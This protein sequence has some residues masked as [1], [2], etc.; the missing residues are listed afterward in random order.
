VDA[1]YDGRVTYT[2]SSMLD[3]IPD[4]YKKKPISLYDP[5][6]AS[7]L[8]QYRL[9][10]PRTRNF[11]E[12]VQFAT[13][14]G[15]YLFFMTERDAS[16]ISISEL[17]FAVYAFGW[18]LDQIATMLEHGWQVYTQNLWSFLDVTFSLLYTAYLLLRVHAWRTESQQL[19]Q[20]ALDVLAMGAPVLVPRIAFVVLSDNLLFVCL[21]AM[22]ADFALLTALAAWCFLGFLLSL[23]W[24][25]EGAHPTVTISKWMIYIWFG[26]DGTGIQRSAEFHWLLGPG[27]MV[28]FAFLGNTLFLTILV[29][30]LSNTFGTIV[31]N[32]TA[33]IQYRHAVLTLEGVKSDAIFAYQP[34]FNILALVV[35]VP[36]KFLVSPR[37]FHKIHVASVRTLNLPLLL[38]IAAM[39]RRMLWPGAARGGGPHPGAGAA[40]GSGSGAPP[41]RGK[42][43]Y[44]GWWRITSHSDIYGVFDLP[45][46]DSVEEQIAVDD[47]LTRH[48][49][50]RQYT[51]R[52]TLL[53]EPA[54]ARHHHHHRHTGGG[55]GSGE[56][57]DRPA[58][59]S[60]SASDSQTLKGS[61]GVGAGG[62]DGVRTPKGHKAPSRRDSM[63][64]PA[65][66]EEL[67]GVLGESGEV[68]GMAGRLEALEAGMQRMERM[69]RRV[70]G[71]AADDDDDEDDEDDDEASP[72]VRGAESE[73]EQDLV[74][75]DGEI[76]GSGPRG[77]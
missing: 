5:R 52:D 62:S 32:A 33:E 47:E 46:P 16:R 74:G 36:L 70:L 22:M 6:E 42:Q 55:G 45:P 1:V 53:G 41:Q 12:L 56:P 69:L 11:L 63:A 77:A 67:R 66:A 24:L 28:T 21:R 68:G 37:W 35:L 31:S 71:D 57:V 26:L 27:L 49:I 72:A 8:N 14:L 60:A 18:V 48:L 19:G 64:L 44:R 15:T 13:L 9:I 54:G 58:E 43:W 3:I 17:V 39:E 50:R 23:L 2:P 40:A 20:Q 59:S 76:E 75:A 25:G 29:S 34:P 7:L 4:R 73:V 61:S 51:R 30:M 10:V 65:L 38:L